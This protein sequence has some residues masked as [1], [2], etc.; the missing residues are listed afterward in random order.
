[1]ESESILLS[2]KKA[3]ALPA[4]I[5]D[6]DQEIIMFINSQFP[7]LHQLGVGQPGFKITGETE[8]WDSYIPDDDYNDIKTLI[9]LRVRMIFDPPT[10][11]MLEKAFTEQISE[12]EWR[13]NVR[14]EE[15]EWVAPVQLTTPTL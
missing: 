8:T 2:I 1:M 10:L 5:K 6:F 3:L 11:T 9:Y 15:E 12:L 13:I 14:R 7:Y 4:E